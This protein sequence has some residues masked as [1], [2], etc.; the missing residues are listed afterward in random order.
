MYSLFE[1]HSGTKFLI[2]HGVRGMSGSREDGR[3][4]SQARALECLQN[5]L[6]NADGST[7]FTMGKTVVIASVFGPLQA[8]ARTEEVDRAVVEVSITP[9]SGAPTGRELKMQSILRR[10]L[11]ALIVRSQHPRCLIRISL[12]IVEDDGS[13][14][15]ACANAASVALID[16]SIPLTGVLTAVSIGIVPEK[17]VKLLDLT[18]SEEK[19]CQTVYDFSFI[20]SGDGSSLAYADSR[21]VTVPMTTYLDCLEHARRTCT[22]YRAFVRTSVEK[23]VATSS[24]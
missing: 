2:F 8:P 7:R 18:A 11:E 1:F 9:A 22:G 5:V 13:A 10:T 3:E 23:Y 24:R 16:A 6:K 20:G 12:L 4:E 15:A 19:H 21:G 14:L 17:D